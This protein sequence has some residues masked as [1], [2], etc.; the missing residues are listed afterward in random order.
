MKFEW[1]TKWSSPPGSGRRRSRGHRR[2]A[3]TGAQW[4]RTPAGVGGRARDGAEDLRR[5]RLLRER[6][7]EVLRARLDLLLQVGVGL[8]QARRHAVELLGEGLKL[9]ARAHLDALAEVA[10]LH[11]LGA[12]LEGADGRDHPTREHQARHD[13]ERDAEDEEERGAPDGRAERLEGL[14]ERLL[15]EDRPSQ[16]RD[17]RV[18]GE[19]LLPSCVARGV[20]AG[21][22]LLA[23]SRRTGE[24]RLDL[25]ETGK[26]CLLK[27]Q[28]NVRVRDQ[29]ALTIDHEGFALSPDPDPRYHVPDELEVHLHHG[30][31]GVLAPARD[32]HRHVGLGFLPEVDRTI[33]DPSR[34]GL[35]E[36][37]IAGEIGLAIGNVHAQPREPE[38]LAAGAVEQTHLGDREH[39]PEEPEVVQAAL[40]DRSG[41]GDELGLAHPAELL[42]DREDEALDAA[43]RGLRLLLLERH[44]GRLVLEVREVDLDEAIGEKRPRD[45]GY[46]GDDVLPEQLAAALHTAI[47]QRRLHVP[48]IADV[49]GQACP[50]CITPSEV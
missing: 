21:R 47:R 9:V 17:G 3:R 27:H 35:G 11:A 12:R 7:G 28:A 13:G 44:E 41:A 16:R 30:D 48:T 49:P 45:H 29:R 14:L 46:E 2:A 1:A 36:A 31:P 19:H 23:G 40:L 20:H 38:L 33:V 18:R 43:G 37:G 24:R 8:L 25:L 5:R 22:R 10:G 42:L 6:L 50:R 15:D 4:C 32:G 26:A 34:L 39:L